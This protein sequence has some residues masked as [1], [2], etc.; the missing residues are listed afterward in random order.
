[1]TVKRIV[2]AS[3]AL[4]VCCAIAACAN[5]AAPAREPSSALAIPVAGT[6][7]TADPDPDPDPATDFNNEEETPMGPIITFPGHQI[8]AARYRGTVAFADRAAEGETVCR[9]T[10]FPG[11]GFAEE[12]LIAV[13]PDTKADFDLA[14]I[15]EGDHLEVTFLPF[16]EEDSPVPVL[17]VIRLFP[18]EMVYYN[19]I[20]VE[21]EIDEDG[22]IDLVMVPQGT[23]LESWGDPMKQFIFHARDAVFATPAEELPEGALLNIYHKGIA[24]FSIPPQGVALEVRGVVPAGTPYPAP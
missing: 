6:P 16:R 1:M 15:K 11:S 13:G 3:L 8:D 23:P 9:L 17:E 5:P 20:M 14:E 10:A 7:E 12:L 22:S 4:A 2:L 18:A 21:R 19:G 24:T